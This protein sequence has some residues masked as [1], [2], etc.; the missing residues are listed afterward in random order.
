MSETLS[1]KPLDM[2]NRHGW[3]DDKGRFVL[4]LGHGY[5]IHFPKQGELTPLFMVRFNGNPIGGDA[6]MREA[7]N[8]AQKHHD[9]Y[10]RSRVAVSPLPVKPERT[11]K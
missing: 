8:R 4:P 9:D 6:G 11:L 1:V 5:T 3:T 10:I 2:D 7:K